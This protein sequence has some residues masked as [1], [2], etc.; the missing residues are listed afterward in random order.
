VCSDTTDVA[1]AVNLRTIRYTLKHH[2]SRLPRIGVVRCTVTE[3]KR[4]PSPLYA[5]VFRKMPTLDRFRTGFPLLRAQ[6]FALG[7]RRLRRCI[8]QPHALRRPARIGGDDVGI[9]SSSDFRAH[10]RRR[11]R[12]EFRA[13]GV[14]TTARDK[15]LHPARAPGV[16]AINQPQ[17]AQ[18]RDAAQAHGAR[19][20]D[21]SGSIVPRACATDS[22]VRASTVRRSPR[23][24][25][26]QTSSSDARIRPSFRATMRAMA[27]PAARIAHGR[28]PMALSTTTRGRVGAR[29]SAV[30]F[31]V[32]EDAPVD[33]F[34]ALR[35]VPVRSAA[36]GDMQDLTEMWSAND[37]VVVTFLRSFG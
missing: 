23:E 31:N 33:A 24:R 12:R 26:A 21:A 14:E 20:C 27:M 37:T 30:E 8:L 34:A 3:R 17:R 25:V 2:P 22:G 7:R 29:A 32:P 19:A 9:S 15:V 6:P 4:R 18:L 36:T 10:L 16:V 28:C 13:Q 11:R 35:G 5:R 1:R